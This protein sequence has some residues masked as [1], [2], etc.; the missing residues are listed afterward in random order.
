MSM[1]CNCEQYLNLELRT[2]MYTR[3]VMIRH[4][5]VFVCD[6]CLT[7]EL[8]P[9]MR[10][11]L[12]KCV[13][14]LGPN[15]SDTSFSLA[16][17]HELARLIYE[18]MTDADYSEDDFKSKLEYEIQERINLLLDLYKVAESMNDHTWIGE[19]RHRLSQ[20]SVIL[21]EMNVF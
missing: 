4:V 11:S 12:K 19:I 10:P 3:S 14:L 18:V 16:D 15:P 9:S 2:V 17:F 13:E 20:L 1:K 21:P 5:P 8:M 6:H 7:Y